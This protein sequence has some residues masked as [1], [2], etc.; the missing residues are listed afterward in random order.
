MPDLARLDQQIEEGAR[1]LRELQ[2]QREQVIA[3]NA[4]LHELAVYLHDIECKQ[5]HTD[6]CGWGYEYRT[7]TV[8]G[9]SQSLP[10]WDRST[11]RRYLARAYKV[12]VEGG[13][14]QEEIDAAR[15]VLQR[16]QEIR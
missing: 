6:M 2:E 10:D 1:R 15:A 4:N 14:T 12:F 13:M 5:N 9:V 8:D 16:L 7:I 3:S 11:H